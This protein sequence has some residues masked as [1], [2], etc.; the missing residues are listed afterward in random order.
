ML[1]GVWPRL[2]L[3]C[4]KR[5]TRKHG[6]ADGVALGANDFIH[7]RSSGETSGEELGEVF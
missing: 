5:K 4:Q 2:L 3:K 1:H 6:L 7:R